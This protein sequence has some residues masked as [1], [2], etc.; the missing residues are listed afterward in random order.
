[1]PNIA[2][3]LKAEITRLARKETRDETDGLKKT[4]SSQRSEIA[5]LKRR[6]F[7]LEK[8]VLRLSK[9]SARSQA[10]ANLIVSNQVASNKDGATEESARRFSSKGMATN[11]KRLGLS[12]ADFGLLVGAT[13]QSVY[14]W[15]AGKARPKA[16]TL[17]AIA[18][19]RGVGKREVAE[20]L[21]GL[22]QK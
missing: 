11:R 21:A 5:S 3:V 15:E 7:D 10:S 22:K 19:L 9:L 2:N 20:R 6:L 4:V 8:T 17:N 14:A 12:A 1:M 13:G 18:M 16:E